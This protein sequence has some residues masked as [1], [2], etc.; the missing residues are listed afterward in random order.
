MLASLL[1]LSPWVLIL[2]IL[3]SSISVVE[4]FLVDRSW[5]ERTTKIVT[6]ILAITLL[7]IQAASNKRSSAESQ[8]QLHIALENQK[9]QITSDLTHAFSAGTTEV[10]KLSG[11][12]A[13]KTRKA[14]NSQTDAIERLT[15]TE[16][17]LLVD[18]SEGSDKCPRVFAESQNNTQ[19]PY[20]LNVDNDDKAANLYD[21]VL[22]VQ[23]GEHTGNGQ[24]FRTL[25][26]ETLKFPTIYKGAMGS[27]PFQFLSQRTT[28]YLQ[29]TLATRRKICSGQIVLHG[30]G[31]GYWYAQP[32]PVHEGP[33][34]S[35]DTEVP[36]KDRPWNPSM[37]P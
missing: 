34:S 12:E 32:Y 28:S 23:E 7:F 3:I 20:A 24:E 25:Q 4:A 26:Q 11:Q 5:K 35:H 9:E 6:A 27:Q 30:D 10:L 29:F 14:A 36:I 8:V 22:Y 1:N 16:S 19:R 15:A 21:V 31:N 17:D 13:D 18:A 33:L 37:I 2:G